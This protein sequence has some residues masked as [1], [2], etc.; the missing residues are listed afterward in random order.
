M[1]KFQ[2]IFTGV[3]VAL[4]FFAV[5]LFSIG[6]IGSSNNQSSDLV[7][8]GTLN[9]AQFSQIVERSGLKNNKSLKFTYVQKND[10]TFDTDFIEALASGVGPDL[11]FL[12]QNSILKHQDKLYV[13]PYKTLSERDFKDVFIEEGELYLTSKGVLGIPF[14]IDP[15]VMYWNRTIFSNA[16][17]SAPPKYWSDLYD[18]APRLVTKDGALNVRQSAIAFGE[19]SNVSHAQDILSM[20][21]MQAGG[22]IA[23]RQSDVVTSTLL[24]KYNAPIVPANT[25]LSFYTEFTNPLK[26]FYSWNRSL[27]ASKN[28]FISGDL[29][30]YIGYAS[31]VGEIRAKNPNLNFDVAKVPQS[32]ETT[33]TLTF[34]SMQALAI[35]KASKKQAGAVEAA[36]LLVGKPALT[37]LINVT[38]LPPVRRD[39]LLSQPDDKYMSIFY[40][41]AVQAR[42][43]LEPDRSQTKNI[44]KEMIE[45][46]T[47]GRRTIN[48][49]VSR[50]DL[51]LN[52]LYKE[53]Q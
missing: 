6:G 17:V 53:L 13:I 30:I 24:N 40:E 26:P 48:E 16:G 51:E 33:Q 47:S 46:V 18:L 38:S 49:S 34:G 21:V 31:E 2:L 12:P 15:L 27:L 44:F 41:S 29:A 1:S 3:F 23:E 10:A 11:F 35:P 36:L 50:T 19:Y 8:W 7:V 45:S 5:I 9:A 32:K 43:W 22:K 25:A 20:L 52:G 28:Y 39:M 4:I 37:E 42:A 14:I